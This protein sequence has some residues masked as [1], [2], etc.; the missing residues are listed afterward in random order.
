MS[1]D[2]TGYL[3]VAKSLLESR[4]FAATDYEARA[5]CA[6]SRA[7]YAVAMTARDQLTLRGVQFSRSG[8]VHQEIGAH[9]YRSDTR[10]ARHF[11]RQLGRLRVLR[12]QADYDADFLPGPVV[13]DAMREASV[14]IELLREIL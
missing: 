10:S 1:F 7:Y 9:F 8:I 6:I 4:E 12:N 14:C 5:R 13:L 11:A 3:R 2:W